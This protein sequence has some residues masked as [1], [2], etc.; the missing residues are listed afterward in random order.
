MCPQGHCLETWV[1]RAPDA[2]VKPRAAAQQSFQNITLTFVAHDLK[3]IGVSLTHYR[4]DSE[5]T[6]VSQAVV[7]N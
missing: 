7:A 6:Y 2:V 1:K 3:T 4:S 5:P